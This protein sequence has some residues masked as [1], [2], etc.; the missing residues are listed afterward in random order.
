VPGKPGTFRVRSQEND[1]FLLDAANPQSIKQVYRPLLADGR[2]AKRLNEDGTTR[3]TAELPGRAF[4]NR[5]PYAI[6][7]G[8]A[9]V[10][11][12]DGGLVAFND[13]NGERLW[14]QEGPNNRLCAFGELVVAVDCTNKKEGEKRLM[15]ARKLSDGS[16][17]WH[18]KLPPEREPADVTP[19]GEC[20]LVRMDDSKVKYGKLVSR[21]GKIVL[22]LPEFVYRAAPREGGWLVATSS[23]LAQIDAQGKAAWEVS[24]EH[25]DWSPFDRREFMFAGDDIYAWYWGPISDSGVEVRRISAKTGKEAWKARCKSLGVPHSKYRH[26]AYLELRGE[27]LIVVSQG[28]GGWFIEVLDT[29]DGKQVCRW[30]SLAKLSRYSAVPTPSAPRLTHRQRNLQILP[31]VEACTVRA[32][33]YVVERKCLDLQ[34]ARF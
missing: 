16:E 14:K 23:R 24:N 2:S 5:P 12:Y 26:L 33:A 20:V 4:S 7:A 32:F 17:A 27:E 29:E 8:K 3:W 11:A 6:V 22:D 30:T 31:Q 28:S 21:E 34:R 19:A 25:A 9:S 18:I 10:V 15:V 1:E 13:E